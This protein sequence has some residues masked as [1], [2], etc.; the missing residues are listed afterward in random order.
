MVHAIEKFNLSSAVSGNFII[1]ATIAT[2]S[3]S[4]LFGY[5]GNRFG[6][7]VNLVLSFIFYI[8][9][10]IS[11]IIAR[12]WYM[13]YPVFIF[14]ALSI[15]SFLV[16]RMVFIL[17]FAPENKRPTYIGLAGL[18]VAPFHIIFALT[19]GILADLTSLSYSLA[20]IVSIALQAAGLIILIFFV[21]D[22]RRMSKNRI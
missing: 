14:L 18:I 15:C 6:H 1:A 12:E 19:G 17:E 22:P 2:M 16:S 21:K 13:M 7:K 9:A 3:S 10:A 8:M 20:F 5:L 4:L 11:A